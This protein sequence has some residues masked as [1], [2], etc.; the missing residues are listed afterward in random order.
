MTHTTNYDLIKQRIGEGCPSKDRLVTMYG[1]LKNGDPKLCHMMR[2]SD[3]MFQ[4][5]RTRCTSIMSIWLDEE[6]KM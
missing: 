4:E 3:C 1:I 2:C 6:V 5:Y